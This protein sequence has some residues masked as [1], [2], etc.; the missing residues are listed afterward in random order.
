MPMLLSSQNVTEYLSQRKLS[1]EQNLNPLQIDPLPA[2]NF[3]LL[4]TFANQGKLLIK[5]ERHN[6]EGKTAGEFQKEW[7]MQ[8]FI[9]KFPELSH[10]C[11][12]LPKVLDFDPDNSIIVFQYLTDYRDLSDFYIKETVFPVEIAATIGTGLALLHQATFANFDY[13]DFFAENEVILP[14]N[15]VMSLIAG[16]ERITPEIFG[17]VPFDG[18]KFFALYQRY[19]SLG[20]ALSELGTAYTPS[21]LT[22][23]DLKLNNILIHTNWE[24]TEESKVRLIDWERVNWGD[25]AFDLGMLIASYIQLWLNSLVISQSISIEESLRLATIPLE[26]LQPSIAKLTQAYCQKFPQILTKRTDFIK[27]VVQFSGL[28]MIQQ[29]QAMIQ[30]QK[31]FGNSGIAMLQVAKSLL[32]RPEQSILTVFGMTQP[33]LLS[34]TLST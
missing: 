11:P 1:E 22:H 4:L 20:L 19:D 27:R 31:S 8:E 18:L 7:Q 29:I 6:Q 10:L 16:L 23:N 14:A 13:R 2:K 33:E 25:P 21:C 28:A 30:Y 34:F 24:T 9:R 12:F 26:N 3:N 17:V 32:C 15:L 5:Q